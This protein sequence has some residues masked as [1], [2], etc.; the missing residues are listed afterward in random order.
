MKFNV[1]RMN[2]IRDEMKELKDDE[3]DDDYTNELV[4]KFKKRVE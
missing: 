2:E 3:K 4:N 1:N